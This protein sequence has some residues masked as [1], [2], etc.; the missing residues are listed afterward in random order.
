MTQYFTYLEFPGNFAGISLT[1]HHHLGK[2]GRVNLTRLDSGFHPI[3]IQANTETEVFT[4]FGWY[5]FRVQMTPFT[6]GVW[7]SRA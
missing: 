4:V 7:M 6:S 1:F 2:I 5:V 3:D